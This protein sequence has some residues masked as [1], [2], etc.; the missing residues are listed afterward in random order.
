MN[1]FSVLGLNYEVFHTRMLHWLWTPDADHGAGDAFLRPFLEL[2]GVALGDDVQIESEAKIA[3]Q[4]GAQWRLADL[5]IR[6]GDQLLLVENKVDPSYQDVDQILDEIDGGI[7][8]A[9]GEGRRFALALIAPGPIST[10]MSEALEHCD[11][12]FVAW[13]ELVDLLN[14]VPRDGLVPTTADII[15]QYLEFCRRPVSTPSIDRARVADDG[16][17]RESGDAVRD[18]VRA[19]N[20]GST[21]TAI[22]VWPQFLEQYPDHAAALDDRWA[23]SRN[24]STKA[25]FA[26]FVQRMASNSDLLEETGEWNQVSDKTWGYSKVRVYRRLDNE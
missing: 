19:F 25:W 4:R 13:N 21:L 11:G 5:L 15:G 18:L 10:T 9:D 7:D 26:A 23:G 14:T 20:P 3:A 17:L 8:V 16:V 6:T 12:R 2:M 22:D 24:F 1:I